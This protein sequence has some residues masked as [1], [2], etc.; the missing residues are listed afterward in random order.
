M[1]ATMTPV[2]IDGNLINDGTNYRAEIISQALGMPSVRAIL[3]TPEGEWPSVSGLA[4]PGRIIQARVHII[5]ADTDTYLTQ[6][7]QWFDPEDEAVVQF[8]VEDSDGS[9][10][11]FVNVLPVG[12]VEDVE[13][14]GKSFVATLQVDGDVR[15]RSTSLTSDE[16]SITASGQTNVVDNTGDDDA[17]PVYKFK[18]T[19][20]KSGG[21]TK[22]RFVPVRWR[23]DVGYDNYPIDIVNASFDTAS[24]VSGGDMQADGDDLRVYVGGTEIDRWLAAMNGVSTKVWC[25]LSFEPRQ[26]YTLSTNLDNTTDYTEVQLDEDI[27]DLPTP[28][29]LLINSEVFVYDTKDVAA[30]KVTDLTRA[31][32]DTSKASHTAGD[33]VIWVQHDLWIFYGD[34]S[35]GAPTVDDDNKPI[36][37]LTGSTNTSWDYDEFGED[38][39]G[40]EGSARTGSWTKEYVSGDPEFYTGNQNGADTSPWEEMGISCL[41]PSIGRWKVYNPCGITNAN[42]QNGEQWS[43]NNTGDH[44]IIV[45]SRNGSTWHIEATVTGPSSASTWE[46]WSQNEALRSDSIHVALTGISGVAGDTE[47]TEVADVTLTLDSSNTPTVTLGAEASTYTLDCTLENQTTGES[48]QI[49]FNMDLN[50]TLEVDTDGRSVVYDLDGSRHYEALTVVDGPRRRWLSLAPGNNTLEFIDAG[51]AALTLTTEFR[52]RTYS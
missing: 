50:Q 8:V 43:E 13:S 48:I 25:N 26:E 49:N 30:G 7:Q 40:S 23:V 47:K 28:G 21:F 12:F 35:L 15:W 52:A 33:T 20:A 3:A 29:I 16:W 5:N 39:V 10:D 14:A 34:S 44:T 9:G 4:R 37:S 42:F 45:S 17:I 38:I 18:P 2:S 22:R 32:K 6:L 27:S 46:S 51:V 41:F 36:F 11:R 1:S 24:E 31:A 19:S